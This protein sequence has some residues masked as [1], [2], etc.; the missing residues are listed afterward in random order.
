MISSVGWGKAAPLSQLLLPNESSTPSTCFPLLTPNTPNYAPVAITMGFHVTPK[1]SLSEDEPHTAVRCPPNPEERPSL[2]QGSCLFL[3]V[4]S[5]LRSLLMDNIYPVHEK[6]LSG[7]SPKKITLNSFLMLVL[8]NPV[9]PLRKQTSSP[10]P[11]ESE[12]R[13]ASESFVRSDCYTM[14]ERTINTLQR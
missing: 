14:S 6:Y 1:L 10:G 5:E 13:P 9:C 8:V 11:W 4:S 3:C 7:N 2:G 12:L